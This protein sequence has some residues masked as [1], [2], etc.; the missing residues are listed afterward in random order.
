MLTVLQDLQRMAPSLSLPPTLS[1]ATRELSFRFV[2]TAAWP[3]SRSRSQ[4]GEDDGAAQSPSLLSKT[5]QA[6]VVSSWGLEQCRIIM[7]YSAAEESTLD[8]KCSCAK[9][10]G[11]IEISECCRLSR[12]NAS[13]RG[14]PGTIED[15][16]VRGV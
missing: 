8:T 12:S 10:P 11:L 1:P 15:V 16:V 5:L 2:P 9:K 6:K 14:Y 3:G 7:R 4:S 13:F